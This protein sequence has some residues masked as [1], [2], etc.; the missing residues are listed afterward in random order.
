MSTDEFII[1]LFIRVDS[2]L[3][4][5]PKRADAHLFPSEIVTLALLFALKGVGQRAFY[6][7]LHNNYRS[8][9]P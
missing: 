2:E 5:M 4:E 3:A 6:R 1:A 8:W 9:F 7:W